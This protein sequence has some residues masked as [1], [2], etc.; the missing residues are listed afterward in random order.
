MRTKYML[1]FLISGLLVACATSTNIVPAGKDTF[2]IAGDDS[3]DT[4]SGK[5]IKTTLY[6]KAN[7]YCE[8]NG[9]KLQPL[10][11]SVS[12]YSAE[13]R[14]RCLKENDPGYTRPNME[15]VPN[16]KIETN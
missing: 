12:S 15:T 14:F 1:V 10:D 7:S 4:I 5:K 11:E 3:W 13:L 16:V 2:L 9:K 8:K 6:Q